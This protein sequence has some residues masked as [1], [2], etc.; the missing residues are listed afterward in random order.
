[1]A[2]VEPARVRHFARACNLR[3]KSDRIDAEFLAEF[4]PQTKPHPQA[5]PDKN[6]LALREL[7][8]H[9]LQ[10]K[11]MLQAALQQSRQLTLP[12]L[13]RSGSLGS[14]LRGHVRKVEKQMEELVRR[15]NR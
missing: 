2:V 10:L 7:G 13:R 14:R 6:T 11:E 5:P 3:S 4:G 1:M 15:T 12:V 9:R 8:R